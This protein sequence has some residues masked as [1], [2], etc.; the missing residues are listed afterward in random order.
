V[1]ELDPRK[2]QVEQTPDGG[3]VVTLENGVRKRYSEEQLAEYTVEII[4]QAIAAPETVD[5]RWYEILRRCVGEDR[6]AQTTKIF[7]TVLG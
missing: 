5:E 3:A 1:T 6:W 2:V 4:T 7:A